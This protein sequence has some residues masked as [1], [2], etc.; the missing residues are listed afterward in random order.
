[1]EKFL[2]KFVFQE[3]NSDKGHLRA[4]ASLMLSIKTK[5]FLK[6]H[7]II[8]SGVF[9]I[10]MSKDREKKIAILVMSFSCAKD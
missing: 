3:F 1:M 2:V 4:R 8:S 6:R 10:S 9:F 5:R 7:A